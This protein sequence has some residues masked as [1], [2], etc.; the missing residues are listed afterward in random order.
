MSD[1]FARARN[2]D[3]ELTTLRIDNFP[4]AYIDFI[5]GV[6]L[7]RGDASRQTLVMEI[8]EAYVRSKAQEM[9]VVQRCLGS[10]TSLAELAGIKTE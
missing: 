8:L 3:L 1:S 9:I 2:P 10:N 6:S 4:K 7:A 5:D